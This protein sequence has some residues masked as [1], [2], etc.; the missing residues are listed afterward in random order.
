MREAVLGRF[1]DS[2]VV[3]KAAAV[4]DYRPGGPWRNKDE[5]NRGKCDLK[6]VKILIFLPELGKLKEG[7]IIVGFA[8]ESG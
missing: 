4:A 7:R 1:A 6:L 8:A 3:V 2:T 5:E